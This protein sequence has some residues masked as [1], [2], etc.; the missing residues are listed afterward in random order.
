MNGYYE[1]VVALL[2]EAGWRHFRAG[3]GSH[4]IWRNAAGET[5]TVPYNCKSRHTANDILKD[6]GIPRRF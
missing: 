5:L 1:Q 2:R 4:E 6:A 3:K